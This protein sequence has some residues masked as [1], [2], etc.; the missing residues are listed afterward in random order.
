M[1]MRANRTATTRV[2]KRLAANG[3]KATFW[4]T[5]RW[6]DDHLTGPFYSGLAGGTVRGPGWVESN[7]PQSLP[8]RWQPPLGDGPAMAIIDMG[9]HVH[10]TERSAREQA[11]CLGCLVLQ[12]T[13]HATDFV[14]AGVGEAVFTKVR[15]LAKDYHKAIK[16]AGAKT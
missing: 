3:G 6:R 5:Y 4:K 12:V 10:T 14:A 7:R 16:D 2:E 9:I 15:I 13:A 8:P 1:C 11:S